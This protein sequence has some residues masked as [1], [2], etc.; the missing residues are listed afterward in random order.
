MRVAAS[1]KGQSETPKHVRSDGSF[2]RKRSLGAGDGFTADHCQPCLILLAELAPI[3]DAGVGDRGICK[4]PEPAIASIF[5][6]RRCHQYSPQC[7]RADPREHSSPKFVSRL[8]S[9][10]LCGAPSKRAKVECDFDGRHCTR[11]L[12]SGW[13]AQRGW[14]QRLHTSLA[15]TLHSIKVINELPKDNGGVVL[16]C[17]S[18]RGN[19]MVALFSRKPVDLLAVLASELQFH[20]PAPASE[21][22]TAQRHLIGSDRRDAR[23]SQALHSEN[24][25]D[26]AVHRPDLKVEFGPQGERGTVV[27]HSDAD[28]SL[29]ALHTRLE[30]GAVEV[31]RE[32]LRISPGARLRPDI[33]LPFFHEVPNHPAAEPPLDMGSDRSSER[34]E[35]EWLTPQQLAMR[36]RQRLYATVPAWVHGG[37]HSDGEERFLN[38]GSAQSVSLIK[39]ACRTL[40]RYTIICLGASAAAAA[41]AYFLADKSSTPLSA[42][43][44]GPKFVVLNARQIAPS[45]SSNSDPGISNSTKKGHWAAARRPTDARNRAHFGGYFASQK[46]STTSRYPIAPTNDLRLE[47]R[48]PAARST[49]PSAA[50]AV[51]TSP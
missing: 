7:S 30:S 42:S 21:I 32:T 5:G 47:D 39:R 9:S 11:D 37:L 31:H 4:G 19:I 17:P 43:A 44:P 46:S 48:I 12:A 24:E 38:T 3:A 40:R 41:P 51:A 34:D 13:P 8:T 6:G 29:A 10:N 27:S 25:D 23:C 35:S 14:Q 36:S 18:R 22:D 2:P 28:K 20:A 33:G 26:G 1:G 15:L 16:S 45:L 50:H 49:R